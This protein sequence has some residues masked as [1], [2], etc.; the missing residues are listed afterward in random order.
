MKLNT[1][2]AGEDQEHIT[3][4]ASGTREYWKADPK[5]K[6]IKTRNHGYLCVT[7]SLLECVCLDSYLL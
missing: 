4:Y 7:D 1:W 6:R 5:G 2:P 3:V